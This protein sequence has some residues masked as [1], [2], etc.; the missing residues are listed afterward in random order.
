M[1]VRTKLPEIVRIVVGRRGRVP[2]RV[3]LVIRFDYGSIVPW[4]RKA[5]GGITAVAGPDGLL[6]RSPV[7]MRGQD[8]TTVA[9]FDVVANQELAFD[10]TWFPSHEDVTPQILGRNALGE[11][12]AWWA[13]W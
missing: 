11:T 4:V 5:N 7:P 1:P 13:E 8:F 9:E 3:E 2:M 10:L 6:L 12:E